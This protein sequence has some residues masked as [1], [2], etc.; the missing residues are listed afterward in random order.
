MGSVR[1]RAGVPG[2]APLMAQRYEFARLIARGVNNSEACRLVGVN[3]RTGT[4]WRFGRT[5]TSS[6]GAE[7][8]YPS[9]DTPST[10]SLSA[11]FL[12]EDERVVIGDRVRAGASLR[13]IGREL[14]RPAS[15]IS[16]EVARNRDE[17][18]LYR[19]FAA[20][21]MAIRRLVRPK[22]RKVAADPVL[23]NKVQEW[24]DLR[25]SPEQIAH[26]LRELYPDNTAWHLVHESIYQAIYAKDGPLGRDRFTCLRTRRRR[27][28]PHRVPGAR[29]PGSLREMTMIGDRPSDVEDR[30]VAGH[31]EGDL[32]RHEALHY[33]AEVEDH[34]RRAVAAA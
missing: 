22:E 2:P 13:A 27:R 16:R 3:R 25:W 4:R 19:P 31:W 33:R 7:L 1:S 30:A 34:R 15:T 11:R 18:G 21:R 28:R 6:S 26:T 14:G 12:S 24:L 23:R 9:M 8:H 10:T 17:A 32:V 20:H 5:V 29:R